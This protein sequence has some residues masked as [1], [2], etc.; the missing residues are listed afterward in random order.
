[1]WILY[2]VAYLIYTLLRGLVVEWYPYPFLDPGNGGYIQVAISS[3]VITMLIVLCASVVVGSRKWI[4]G[5]QLSAEV[6]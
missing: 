2:P 4:A 3:I 6:K 5:R 1:L